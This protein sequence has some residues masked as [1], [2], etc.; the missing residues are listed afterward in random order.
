MNNVFQS[1]I[2]TLKRSEGPLKH[3]EI[4]LKHAQ[5]HAQRLLIHYGF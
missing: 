5:K 3:E 2:C 1:F 4:L